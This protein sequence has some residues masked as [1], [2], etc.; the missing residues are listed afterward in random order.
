M[1]QREEKED[2]EEAEEPVSIN[3]LQKYKRHKTRTI[4][5]RR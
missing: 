3:W 1:W 2:E 4:K 5:R